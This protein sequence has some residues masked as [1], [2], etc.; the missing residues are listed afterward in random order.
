MTHPF[1]ECEED[2]YEI[3]YDVFLI[4][5]VRNATSDQI[6]EMMGYI[7]GLE[8][9]GFK[10]Y[11]PARDTNQNDNIGWR[12]CKDNYIAIKQSKE[13]HIFWDSTST[14]SLFDLGIAFSM[15]KKLK[16]VNINDVKE[17]ETKSFSN[18]LLYWNKQ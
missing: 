18:L 5:P 8:A 3:K 7:S 15:N 14:G 11:Y 2:I 17:T 13:V 1:P 12:I 10:V 16:I 9:Q 6:T 4:C